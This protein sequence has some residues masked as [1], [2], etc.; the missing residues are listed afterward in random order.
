MLPFN[1]VTRTGNRCGSIPPR[2]RLGLIDT[3]WIFVGIPTGECPQRLNLPPNVAIMSHVQG[4]PLSAV[5]ARH[6][7][8]PPIGSSRIWYRYQSELSRGRYCLLRFLF[9]VAGFSSPCR[10]QWAERSNV[11][12]SKPHSS[13]LH[14]ST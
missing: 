3:F 13:P 4:H 11:L 1:F 7:T 5:V 2:D 6:M 10:S 12:V 9:V 14:T 8:S